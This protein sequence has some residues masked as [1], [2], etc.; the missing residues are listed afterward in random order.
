MCKVN[1]NRVKGKQNLILSV[2]ELTCIFVSLKREAFS[3]QMYD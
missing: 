1:E 2:F 3:I